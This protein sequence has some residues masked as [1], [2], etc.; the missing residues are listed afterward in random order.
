MSEKT[1]K[2]PTREQRPHFVL[3]VQSSA[4]GSKSAVTPKEK[5]DNGE[6]GS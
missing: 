1:E 5:K 2:E 4:M 3:T 6:S